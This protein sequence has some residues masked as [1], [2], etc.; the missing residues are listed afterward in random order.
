[1]YRSTGA[2]PESTRKYRSDVPIDN[3]SR[4]WC[5][6]PRYGERDSPWD[7]ARG[8]WRNDSGDS[9]ERGAE[10]VEFAF[11]VVLLI[12]LLY[13]IISY[14]LVLAAQ[15]TLTQAAADAARAGIVVPHDIRRHHRGGRGRD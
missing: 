12:A 5:A 9:D 13:G 4:N 3:R 10:M 1:M 2:G 15:S 7:R 14:G 6:R 11:V 8:G